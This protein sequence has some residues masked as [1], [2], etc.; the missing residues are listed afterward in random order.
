M[1]DRD[2]RII[3]TALRL[4]LK[5]LCILVYNSLRKAEKEGTLAPEVLKAQMRRE[6]EASMFADRLP[7]SQY[8]RE[9][10]PG[11]VNEEHG[12]A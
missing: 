8:E 9:D 5:L 1:T 7:R 10:R 3:M 12:G 6:Q 11:T 2:T 4:C